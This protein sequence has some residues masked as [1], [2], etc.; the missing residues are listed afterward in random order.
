MLSIKCKLIATTHL[1]FHCNSEIFSFF[2][3]A[4]GFV[5]PPKLPSMQT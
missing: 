2:L 1:T 3:L 4:G 5:H